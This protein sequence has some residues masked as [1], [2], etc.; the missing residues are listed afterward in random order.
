MEILHVSAECY[1]V[2]KVGGLGDVAGAMPKYQQ[3]RGHN[4]KLVMPMYETKFLNEHEWMV[5]YKGNTNLGDYFFNYTV[6]KEKNN[7]LG[8]TL[9]LVDIN[10]LLNRPRVYGYD[11]DPQRFIAFQICVANWLR[12]WQQK[13]NVV[14]CHDYH[15]ALLPFIFQYCYDYKSLANIPTVLTVHNAQ[16]QGWLGWD[17]STWIPRYDLWK[18]GELDWK[19]TINPLASGIKNAW[20]VTAVSPS[21][22]NELRYNSNGLENLF[23]YEKGKCLGILNGIDTE[24]WNPETDELI[25]HHYNEASAAKGKQANK[26][27][28]CNTFGLDK[29][30]PLFIFIGRLVGDKAADVLPDAIKTILYEIKKQANFIVLGN[31]NPDIEYYL[32]KVKWMYPNNYIF[33]KGYN[34]KLSHQLYA[35]ADF[36]LMPSRVEPCGLNQMYAL[37]YGTMPLVRRTGGL[38]DTVTDIGDDGFGICF[39]HA[40]IEDIKQSCYRAIEIYHSKKTMQH[41]RKK[42]MQIDNSWDNTVAKYLDLYKHLIF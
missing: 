13:P 21:Y 3:R 38:Q 8:F 29:N 28:I 4:V 41:Y 23:E 9:Y 31:G 25:E 14:H 36:L 16:Y 5:D 27:T 39:N 32:D 18:A 7:T 19:N 10:G 30:K 42:M 2:A 33:Y 1:P 35:A 17:K 34:E 37:R 6:I 12:Q 15:T 22:M 20:A 24:L 26:E 40:N 11:D